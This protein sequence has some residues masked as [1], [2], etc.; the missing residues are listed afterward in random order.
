MSPFHLIIDGRRVAGD[1]LIDVV[2]PATEEVLVAAPRASRAQLEQA[3]AAARTAFPA[4]AATPIAE[5]RAALL[6]LADAVSA[7]V[8]D[9]ARWLSLEQGK[10]LAHARFEIESFVGALRALPDNPFP[11]K[12]IEDSARRTVELHRRPL[13]VV[14]AI[15][16]WNFPISLLGFKLPLALLAGNTMVIKPAPTTPLTTLK[17]GE[18]CLKTLPPGVVN[19]VVDAN[20]LGAELTRHPDIRKISFTGSTETGRKIMAAASDTLK[21]LTLELGGND[22]AIVLDDV[23]PLVVAPRI[24]GGAFMNSGQVCAAIKRLYVHDSVYDALCDALV[25]LAN[26][27]IVGDGLSEGVQFGPLQNRAQFDKVNALIDEA[28]K[29]GTVI[30]GGAAS[31]GKGYFIRPTLVR[32]ITDG[33]RLVD[34]EQFGPVLPII[35]YTDLDEV[36]ARAN[37]SPFGLGAS[38]WSSDP[39]RAARLAP[40]IEA[41]T[42]WINQHPDFGPHIPFGGAKQ[43]GVGVEMGEEG[44]NEFTQL[45]VVNLAH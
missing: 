41:G 14:A 40:R 32:D 3:V 5:R 2:N 31:G 11:P 8:D 13:G 10:P 35:R 29:I 18:L 38:I 9:L 42:V 27:A 34:E 17:I 16:P 28:G 39:Q 45:Q 15:V 21:R 22:P 24:F 12:I 37:A 33:A 1:G 4:W 44:L 25:G 36:I 30:A 23:D 6:R 7:Q 19:V 20:D 43:S 26:A